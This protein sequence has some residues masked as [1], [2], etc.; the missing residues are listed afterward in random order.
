MKLGFFKK[1]IGLS[2]L[3]ATGNA[4]ATTSQLNSAGYYRVWQGFKKQGMSDTQLMSELPSFMKDTVDLY[5]SA[6]ALNQYLVVIPPKI[7]PDFIPDE[8]ALVALTSEKQYQDIRSTPEGRKY[9]DRHWDVFEKGKSQSAKKFVDYFAEKPE[10]LDPTVAYNLLSANIDWSS[11][12]SLAFIGT[13]KNDLSGEQYLTRLKKHIELA[14]NNM[15][16]LGLKGYIVTATENY[17]VAYLNWGSKTAHDNALKTAAGT[18]VFRDAGE[19]MDTLMYEPSYDLVA[20]ETID[21]GH[22]Y[23]T[24]QAAKKALIVVT[25]HDQL[26]ATGKKTGYYFPEVAHP[27]YELSKKGIQVDIASPRGGLAPMDPKSLNLNDS[28][29]KT[30]NSDKNFMKKL[31]ATKRVGDIDPTQYSAIIFAGGHGTMWDFRD[32][33]AIQSLTAQ[34]YEQ[35]GVVA[36]VCHGPAA[37]VDVKLQ[38]GTYLIAGKNVTGFTNEEEENA[39]LT[40]TMP[41]LL[42]DAM[43]SRGAKFQQ[44]DLWQEKVVVDGRVVTGQNPASASGVGLAVADLLKSK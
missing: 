19:F 2:L 40:A 23:R 43:I 41:F 28:V 31:A 18:A 36:A 34:V 3:V 14:A 44:A 24:H 11:G 20:G 39:Q 16:P 25:S 1:F 9:S 12:Y 32:S 8:L 6:N 27:Y 26:G 10:Q 33:K 15:G 37:L 4:C 22:F 7:K 38:N 21:H 5:G 17:E 29:N 30:L 13:R 35:G 42:E